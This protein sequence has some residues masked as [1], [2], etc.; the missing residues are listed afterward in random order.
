MIERITRS[1]VVHMIND[2]SV[3]SDGDLIVSPRA[4]QSQFHME[5]IAVR[6]HDSVVCQCG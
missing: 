3:N 2:V 4:E 5:P 1:E 6:D